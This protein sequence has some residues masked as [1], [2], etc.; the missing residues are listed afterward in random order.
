MSDAKEK[1]KEEIE[2]YRAT[3][4]AEFQEK[5]KSVHCKRN[6]LIF[7]SEGAG[8]QKE[9]EKLSAE[10]EAEI[11]NLKQWIAFINYFQQRLR[12]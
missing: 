10:T 4:E 9:V 11:V 1:A 2:S 7:Q 12:G 8:S 5:Q 6:S 3:M